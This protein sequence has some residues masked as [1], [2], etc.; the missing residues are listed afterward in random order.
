MSSPS[1]MKMRSVLWFTWLAVAAT[2][3]QADW[4][5][6]PNR[7]ADV[8]AVIGGRDATPGGCPLVSV[9]VQTSSI[10]A[11]YRCAGGPV[12][13]DLRHPDDRMAAPYRTERFKVA[14]GPAS[15][16]TD[17][18]VSEVLATIRSHET[19]WRWDQTA[20]EQEPRSGSTDSVSPRGWL[21]VAALT[22]V[23]LA[24]V[25]ALVIVLRRRRARSSQPG[26]DVR[27]R[28]RRGYGGQVWHNS[29][30]SLIATAVLITAL[31]LWAIR[32]ADPDFYS[33]DPFH[34]LV[35]LL[36]VVYVTAGFVKWPQVRRSLLTLVFAVP[37]LVLAMEIYLA[38][39][40]R[41]IAAARIATSDDRLLRYTYRPGATVRDAGGEMRITDDGLWDRP[42]VV[43]KPAGVYRVVIL[44]DSVPN[45]PSIPYAKR[46][47][48]MLEAQLARDAPPGVKVEVI[49]VSC[50]GYNT[51]QE[52]RLLE[53][54]GLKYQPD[55]I[56]VTY[57]LNDPFLQNGAYRR[58]GNSFFAF[59]L[60]PWFERMRGG[61][62][63]SLFAPL[64]SSYTFDLVVRAS[65]E[66]LRLLSERSP[67]TVL[68][69]PLPIVERFDDATCL[70]QYDRVIDVARQQ[71]F[72][73]FRMVDA[74]A[75]LDY[76]R[77]L[78]QD[79]PGDITHPNADGHARIART[80]S[81]LIAPLALEVSAS[82][83]AARS[84]SHPDRE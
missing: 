15:A 33:P 71:R 29:H 58:V 49:N 38:E 65:F 23:S 51:I 48:S 6:A 20:A 80:L 68:V 8:L 26:A 56:V 9:A 76:R 17:A 60:A 69:T 42:H 50:E 55:L 70:A 30:G 64:H 78:K 46:F 10:H 2:G 19:T 82:G 73:T 32:S 66:R 84:P 34:G 59:Q 67:F 5:I 21:A 28:L 13:V 43:P 83:E 7:E 77:F 35:A 72:S 75:G 45:D 4:V 62:S 54:V 39:R 1:A 61:S 57:V 36:L 22:T 37:V 12:S 74:F 11:T 14:F 3:V 18:F 47:P 27:V 44:G 53:K 63:C 81:G 52:V 31:S 25:V 16:V 24:A 40:D 41:S 79:A